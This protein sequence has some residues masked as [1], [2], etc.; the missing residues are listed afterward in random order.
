MDNTRF[1]NVMLILG[2]GFDLA[3]D[4]KTRYTLF[5][6]SERFQRLVENNNL[7]KAIKLWQ[8][9][10]SWIDWSDLECG[11][12][13]YALTLATPEEMNKFENEFVALREA[14]FDYLK[15]VVGQPVDSSK[16]LIV[17]QLVDI[18]NQFNP[19]IITFNYTTTTLVNLSKNMPTYLNSA[20]KG[21]NDKCI[22]QHG[23]IYNLADAKDN[24]SNDIVLG[25]DET[26]EVDA[27]LSFLKK[28]SQ[29]LHCVDDTLEK[30]S[31]AN[32]YVVFGCSM[33]D[34]DR[35][36]F[37]MVFNPSFTDKTYIV[38]YYDN[39]DYNKKFN[40]IEKYVGKFSEFNAKNQFYFLASTDPCCV[41][42]TNTILQ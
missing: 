3:Y 21:L 9:T 24:T 4:L 6:N 27:R 32:T 22:F 15:D 41:E 8:E 31:Q 34:S 30:I 7:C 38:Y 10:D 40:N 2:N 5:Y 28:S 17:S 16:G 39:D 12:Y 26:Q 23:M 35:R 19:S 11:L 13:Q 33:G 29:K 25:I 1:S 18:W 42:Q 37:E 20:A 14:L 36:Y